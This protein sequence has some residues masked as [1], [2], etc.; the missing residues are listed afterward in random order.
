MKKTVFITAA[1]VVLISAA[2]AAQDRE[3]SDTGR[4][5]KWDQMT[6]REKGEARDAYARVTE[7]P[8]GIRIYLENENGGKKMEDFSASDRKRMKKFYREWEKL[9]PRMKDAIREKYKRW[10]E[11]TPEQREKIK[12]AYKRYMA[13]T[14]EEKARIREEARKKAH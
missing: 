2:C 10:M 7:V 8:E 11:L 14:A 4:G 12:D 1:I 9:S 5:Q 13:S 3:Y 6:D